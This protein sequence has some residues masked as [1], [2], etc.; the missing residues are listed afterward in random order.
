MS[1]GDWS[2]NDLLSDLEP[3]IGTINS[4]E[5]ICPG[6]YFIIAKEET[7]IL[8]KEYYAVL[9]TAE[10]FSKVKAY[11]QEKMHLRLYSVDTPRSGWRIVAYEAGMYLTRKG[12]PLWLHEPLYNFTV[13]AM[14]Y[15]PE[16]FGEYPVPLCT[17]HGY[18]LRHRAL[19]NG[20]YWI[21]TDQGEDVLAVCYPVWDAELS[22]AVLQMSE[23]TDA[24]RQKG[25]HQTLGYLFFS[26]AAICAALFELM[27]LRPEWDGTL[28]CKPALMNV[29]WKHLPDFAVVT[30]LWEQKVPN[31]VSS[32]M[33]EL[34]DVEIEP[35]L[36]P[37][38]IV[39]MFPDAGEKYMLWG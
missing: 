37:K 7:S 12:L 25:I 31:T 28:I 5:E 9:E 3:E 6:V 19:E 22:K 17:P 13:A 39:T 33:K 18:T 26:H 15:H 8:A 38:H 24:D 10:I 4:C 36:D 2:A 30:N 27:D 1:Q 29:I 35:Q 16:Y 11:G 21:E 34:C 20:I 23:Q 32:L 14:E